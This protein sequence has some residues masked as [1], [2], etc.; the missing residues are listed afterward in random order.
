MMGAVP[1]ADVVVTNPTHLAVAIQYDPLS[2]DAPLVVAKG[3]GL[4]AERIKAIATEN[5]IP[6]VENKELAR[7]LY[8]SIEIG[9]PIG[10]E[11]F[12]G[13]AELLAYVYKMKGKTIG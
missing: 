1:K 5:N 10:S 3:A 7:N 6:V 13:V 11:F 8:K 12:R 9:D 4:V 2:M